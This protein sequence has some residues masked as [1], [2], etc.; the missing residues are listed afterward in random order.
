MGCNICKNQ[1][2]EEE[3]N[4]MTNEKFVNE[5]EYE[6]KENTRFKSKNNN[7]FNSN[8]NENKFTEDNNNKNNYEFNRSVDD[9][10]KSLNDKLDVNNNLDIK[11]G[12][13]IQEIISFLSGNCWSNYLEIMK[14]QINQVYNQR[15]ISDIF[16][17]KL[18]NKVIAYKLYAKNFPLY[19][20]N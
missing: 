11:K 18:K 7:N 12:K 1:K 2:N 5:N 13:S 20:N 9:A 16:E 17:I 15:L 14:N 3:N 4:E 8:E 10:I 6:E 19:S